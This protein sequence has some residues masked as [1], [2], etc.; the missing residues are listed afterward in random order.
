MYEFLEKRSC[1]DQPWDWKKQNSI[2]AADSVKDLSFFNDK[3]AFW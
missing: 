2:I 3:G 1:R